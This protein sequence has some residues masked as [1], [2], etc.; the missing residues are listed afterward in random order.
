M[1]IPVVQI[2]AVVDIAKSMGISRI[3]RGFAITSP[4]GNPIIGTN[5]DEKALRRK[6]I[7]KALEILQKEG[8][9]STINDI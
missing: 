3:L 6:Y 7:E 1:G 8:S 4:V 2:T 5:N 9:P